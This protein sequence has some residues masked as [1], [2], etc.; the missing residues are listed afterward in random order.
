MDQLGGKL[1][2]NHDLALALDLQCCGIE[3]D[4]GHAAGRHI[5]N[6]N[7]SCPIHCDDLAG[8]VFGF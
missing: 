8:R 7:T 6:R 2:S 1:R 4:D 3:M 5:D